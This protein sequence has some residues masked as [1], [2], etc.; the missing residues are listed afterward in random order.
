MDIVINEFEAIAETP[1]SDTTEQPSTDEKDT[2]AQRPDP[3]ALSTALRDL[4]EQA[5]RVWAH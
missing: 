2:R 3:M 5:A 4:A 1:A